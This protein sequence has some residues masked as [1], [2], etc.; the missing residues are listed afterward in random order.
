MK[1]KILEQKKI[2]RVGCYKYAK[3][4]Y[5]DHPELGDCP[6][7]FVEITPSCKHCIWFSVKKVV[8]NGKPIITDREITLHEAES[9]GLEYRK[10]VN[11]IDAESAQEDSK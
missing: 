9:L 8:L 11:V 1:D 6:Y 4:A 10:E 5:T 3:Y 2:I 7:G